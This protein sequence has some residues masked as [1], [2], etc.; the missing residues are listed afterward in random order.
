MRLFR[1]PYLPI[2]IDSGGRSI[3]KPFALLV[4]DDRACVEVLTELVEQ[5]GFD[6]EIV[7]TLAAA[8]EVIIARPPDLLLLDIY[9]PDGKSVDRLTRLVRGTPGKVVLITG[10]PSVETAVDAMRLGAHDYLVKPVDWPRLRAILEG[11]SRSVHSEDAREPGASGQ[12]TAPEILGGS[13]AMAVLNHNIRCVAPTDATVLITGETGTGKGMV[14]ASIHALSARSSKPFVAVA[15][16]SLSTTLLE[17]ELFG[18]ERGSFT[19]ASRRHKGYFERADGGTI[20]LDE[21]TEMPI[22]LQSKLLSVLETGTFTRVC[23]DTEIVVDVRVMAA[24]N[25]LPAAAVRDGRLRMDLYYRLNVFPIE[26][27]ALRDRGTDVLLLAQYFLSLL[28]AAEGSSKMLS[29]SCKAALLKHQWPGNVRELKNAVRRAY[30]VAER[31][32]EA[33]CFDLAPAANDPE[34]DSGFGVR[35]P[36]GSSIADAEKKLILSTLKHCAGH[37]GKTA[38]TLGLSPKTL[39]NRLLEYGA[40]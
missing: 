7:T 40:S 14:A 20:F 38:E 12:F 36:F 21:I 26:L 39:F 6:S 18:H 37:R 17:S 3:S 15:C 4:D 9:L 2:A 1:R 25:R 10:H 29:P 27:A 30:I 31:D 16:S 33:A 34:A 22:D 11:V 13:P 35:I 28:N 5:Q 8:E 24:T 32:I 19:G 23:G